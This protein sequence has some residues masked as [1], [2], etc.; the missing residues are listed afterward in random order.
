VTAPVLRAAIDE[1]GCPL[2]RA[3]DVTVAH[4]RRIQAALADNL[5]GA[6]LDRLEVTRDSRTRSL[7]R[8]LLTAQLR[9]GIS[10][11]VI[12]QRPFAGAPRVTPWTEMALDGGTAP[13]FAESDVLA[14]GFSVHVEL[15][16]TTP[17]H[18]VLPVPAAQRFVTAVW[19]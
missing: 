11:E 17:R 6:V 19:G 16:T 9:S 3:C 10:L 1:H 13:T 7:Y 8:V 12:A 2:S 14:R 4:E 15:T 5:P 18:A